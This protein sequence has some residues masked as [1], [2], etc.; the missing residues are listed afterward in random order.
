M[1]IDESFVQEEYEEMLRR[2]DEGDFDSYLYVIKNR[3]RAKNYQYQTW[4]DHCG[5]DSW[6][7]HHCSQYR[8]CGKRME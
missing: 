3:N 1:K 8:E 4:L 2:A 6:Y 5:E 7:C